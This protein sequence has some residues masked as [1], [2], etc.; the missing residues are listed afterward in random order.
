LLTENSEHSKAREFGGLFS[1]HD[2]LESFFCNG[3]ACRLLFPD[4]SNISSHLRRIISGEEYP[5][6]PTL[7][8]DFVIDLG[9]NVGAAALYFGT[10]YPDAQIASFEPSPSNYRYLVEN[11]GHL[12]HIKTF[13][14]GLLDKVRESHLFLGENH[15][16][17]HSIVPSSNVGEKFEVVNL[18]RALFVL[19]DIVRGRGVLKLD[20][21]GCEVPILRDISGLLL[22]LYLLNT[23]VRGIGE[24]LIIC[25]ARLFLYGEPKQ[26][27]VIGVTLYIYQSSFFKRD[28]SWSGGK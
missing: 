22:M 5:V 14:I 4:T 7:R 3:Q 1:E 6:L 27:L 17:Q 16:L 26:R 13:N 18:Q 11:V 23:I 24:R 8:P 12:P 15:C 10:L 25:F 21:E 28:L 19:Q 20:T 2:R 9:A